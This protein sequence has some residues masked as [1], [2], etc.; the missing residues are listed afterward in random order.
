MEPVPSAILLLALTLFTGCHSRRVGLRLAQEPS[1][2]PR[3]L[4]RG[5]SSLGLDDFS[6]LTA[7]RVSASTNILI[8][9][10]G[11]GG[12][13]A[14]GSC[15]AKID[16][17]GSVTQQVAEF[18]ANAVTNP[19]MYCTRDAVM[20]LA[21]SIGNAVASAYT[22]ARLELKIEG[23]GF[24]CADASAEADSYATAFAKAV[25]RDAV[26]TERF[27]PA[28][29]RTHMVLGGSKK[30]LCLAASLSVVFA[31]AWAESKVVGCVEGTGDFVDEQI[32][33]SKSV[34]NA[35]AR[36]LLDIAKRPCRR[37][38][39]G[40]MQLKALLEE[41][42]GNKP[43]QLDTEA[44]RSSISEFLDGVAEASGGSLL[45]CDTD[46]SAQCC[47]NDISG[48]VLRRKAGFVVHKGAKDNCCCVEG[49]L[50][51]FVQQ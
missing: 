22:L 30:A 46:A 38:R 1:S 26:E 2:A 14:S 16:A 47:G 28:K 15:E 20:T 29:D 24:A 41:L 25:L 32:S 44:T 34:Q 33:F 19:G 39:D 18:M 7:C 45:Q 9:G 3:R 23:T 27:N 40:K 6:D 4:T 21:E 13:S 17:A 37:D 5:N 36:V 42:E 50:P 48:C 10:S 35:I 12:A 49:L 51:Y 8:V 43:Y 11:A 31:K